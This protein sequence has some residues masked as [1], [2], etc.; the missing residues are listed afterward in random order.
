[1]NGY[2]NYKKIVL[3]VLFTFC[4]LSFETSGA[5]TESCPQNNTTDDLMPNLT[6]EEDYYLAQGYSS[7]CRTP[8][9][10]CG[11]PQPGPVGARCWCIGPS[12]PIAGQISTN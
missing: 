10:I 7:I 1:M 2:V 12:G 4:L 6:S 3:I 9:M 11:L 8:K 5:Q